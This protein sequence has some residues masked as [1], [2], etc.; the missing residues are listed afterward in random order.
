MHRRCTCHFKVSNPQKRSNPIKKR[1][2][3]VV[4]AVCILAV[5]FV[6]A[7]WVTLCASFIS[8]TAGDVHTGAMKIIELII[9]G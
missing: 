6:I 9:D 3:L 4:N 1:K 7:V 2:H 5:N 8:R